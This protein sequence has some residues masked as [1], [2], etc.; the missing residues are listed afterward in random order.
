MKYETTGTIEYHERIIGLIRR[1]F[2]LTPTTMRITGKVRGNPF[3]AEIPL[4]NVVP[5]S[6]VIWMR[7]TYFRLASFM[8]VF[9]LV[10]FLVF[11]VRGAPDTKT[12]IV[13]CVGF[14]VATVCLLATLRRFELRQFANNSG[15]V[16]FDI[17][18]SGPDSQRFHD[19]VNAIET[20]ISQIKNQVSS[21]Q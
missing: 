11:L 8:F 20:R 12:L 16:V 17:W 13:S 5:K 4:D 14:G 19:F 3:D 15:L 10:P 7:T 18:R 2:I 9:L 21:E 1:R 6:N